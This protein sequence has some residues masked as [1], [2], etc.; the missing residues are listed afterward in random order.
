MTNPVGVPSIVVA[1]SVSA[2]RNPLGAGDV[3]TYRLVLTNTSNVPAYDLTLTDTL[4]ANVSYIADVAGNNKSSPAGAI[5]APTQAGQQQ[6]WAIG[7][8][9]SGGVAIIVFTARIG[10]AVP[11]NATLL[12][13]ASGGFTSQPGGP[14]SATNTATA[15]V[16]SGD[17]ALS[18]VKSATPAPVLAGALL[19]YT[20]RVSNTGIVS[21]TNVWI[22]DVVPAN[23]SFFSAVGAAAQPLVGAGAGSP[24]QWNLGTVNANGQD[25]RTVTFTVQVNTPLVNGTLLVNTAMVTSTNSVTKTDT[26][27]TP[28]NSSHDIFVVKTVSA[29]GA[30]APGRELLYTLTYS[31][32]GNEPAPNVT[33]RDAIP[34]FTAYVAGSCTGACGGPNPLVWSLGTRNP[35]ASGSVSFSVTVNLSLIH[36]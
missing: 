20:I 26:V 30:V 35:G 32:T 13:T 21:A 15:T 29:G 33:L 6:V 3:V 23:T 14:V 12:N 17:P 11:A 4:P 36:I 24:I 8:L 34:A 2:P 27:T 25:V 31:V 7:Q 28:V 10:A 19:T 5:G 1:K 16:T 9:N 22:T 18:I